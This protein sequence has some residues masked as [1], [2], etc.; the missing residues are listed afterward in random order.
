MITATIQTALISCVAAAYI[1]CTVFAMA[2]FRL[3]SRISSQ[4]E[5]DNA[6]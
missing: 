2:P 5:R 6:R 1:V 4:E 3:S